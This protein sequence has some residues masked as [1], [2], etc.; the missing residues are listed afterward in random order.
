MRDSEGSLDKVRRAAVRAAEDAAIAGIPRDLLEW[1]EQANAEFA[2]SG[3]CP[4]CGSKRV[5]VHHLPCS[6]LDKHPFD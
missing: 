3:G 5:A 2:A 6:E 1:L 4:G